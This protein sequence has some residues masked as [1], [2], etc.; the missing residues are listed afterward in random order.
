MSPADGDSGVEAVT[1]AA[2]LLA[3]G[4]STLG[5]V[6]RALVLIRALQEGSVL[7]VTQAAAMLNV[8]PAT[9][10]R[11]LATL[12]MEGF[13]EQANDRR[14]RAG[15]HLARVAPRSITHEDFEVAVQP[16]VQELVDALDATILVWVRRGAFVRL[17][18]SARGGSPDAIPHDRLTRLPAYATAC[19]RTLLAE[20]P[21]E[22]VEEIHHGGLTPWRDAKITSLQS[23]K[24]R[25]SAVRRERFETTFEEAIQGASGVAQ[26][27][28]DPWGRPAVAIGVA[29][30]S[31]SFSRA[32]IPDYRRILASSCM[33]A[34]EALRQWCDAA[35]SDLPS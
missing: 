23:L 20:L 27:V 31:R 9:A 25:L 22:R 16:V 33:T 19:G 11:L 17:V 32:D 30:P 13:A 12:R 24:R 7:S 3:D 5:S 14:Y 15:T 28:R 6:R 26:C 18:H 21:N 4:E 1:N 2:A 34:E 10:H 29:V 35:P 8:A